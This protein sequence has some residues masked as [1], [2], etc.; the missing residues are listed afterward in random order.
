[1]RSLIRMCSLITMCSLIRMCSLKVPKHMA[2]KSFAASA[3]LPSG[4]ACTICVQTTWDGGWPNA[5]HRE[6]A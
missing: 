2:V 3:L 4:T 6:E 1:M 5:R